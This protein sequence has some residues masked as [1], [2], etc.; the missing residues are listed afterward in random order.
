MEWLNAAA[1][2]RW[3]AGWPVLALLLTAGCA[4][5]PAGVDGAQS[6]D[7]RSDIL[8]LVRSEQ[9]S[10]EMEALF[11]GTVAADDAGCVRLDT[12]DRHT[13]IWPKGFTLE[14]RDGVATVISADG[15]R[16]GELGGH[17]EFG[18]GEVPTLHEGI[19]LTDTDRA[20]AL[21]ACPGRY[22]IVGKA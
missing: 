16:I 12:D 20:T 13:V 17:F 6:F 8:F 9:P 1:P 4:R 21:S 22:W 3:W 5:L 11:K 19:S 18:G 15:R 10:T 2:H 7:A 14:L